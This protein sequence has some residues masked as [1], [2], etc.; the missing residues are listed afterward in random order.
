MEKVCKACGETKALSEFYHVRGRPIARCKPCHRTA[1]VA[2]QMSPPR[3]KTPP[4]TKRCTLC[5]GIKPEAEFFN[6][7]R[8]HDGMSRQC[9]TCVTARNKRW[10]DA[11]PGYSAKKHK[12][13]RAK[14]PDRYRDYERKKNYGLP[15]G[16]FNRLL[17]AQGGRCAICGSD[18]PNG[19]PGHTFAVDHD[20]TTGAVR[21][22]LCA[23]CNHGLGQFHDSEEL[24]MSDLRYIRKYSTS[25]E[26]PT[27]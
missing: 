3:I 19:R 25:A 2:S 14:N 21:R 1:V 13:A 22:I 17:A 15:P 20:H 27:I 18:H 10:H 6:D 11:H 4:G 24:L 5:K 16:E 9:K 7:K 23:K 26:S 8:F 12:E